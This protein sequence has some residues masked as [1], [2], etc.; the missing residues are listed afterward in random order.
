MKRKSRSLVSLRTYRNPKTRYAARAGRRGEACSRFAPHPRGEA[1]SRVRAAL[2]RPLFRPAVRGGTP[3]REAARSVPVDEVGRRVTCAPLLVSPLSRQAGHRRVAAGPSEGAQRG[4][5]RPTRLGGWGGR[6][7]KEVVA[8]GKFGEGFE[9]TDGTRPLP[10][11]T[12]DADEA[13]A[14]GVGQPAA[15]R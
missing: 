15:A 2:A 14:P 11:E 6:Q 7:A 10:P 3:G 9:Y 5:E 13:A 1:R 12:D 8:R 4:C